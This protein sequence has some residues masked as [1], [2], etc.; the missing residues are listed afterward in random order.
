MVLY[1]II[2]A[3][4]IG[5]LYATYLAT[6]VSNQ[7][8]GT[9]RMQKIASSIAKGAMSFLKA[10]YKVL[11]FFIVIV[12]LILAFTADPTKSSWTIVFAFVAGALLSASA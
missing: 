10:E 12:G 4:V 1:R 8:A 6:M 5:L 9:A 2:G 3:G 11:A 7:D